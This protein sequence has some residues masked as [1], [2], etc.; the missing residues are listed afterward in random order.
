MQYRVLL[1]W[2]DF[3]MLLCRFTRCFAK[4][5]STASRAAPAEFGQATGYGGTTQKADIEK[6]RTM[7]PVSS[8]IYLKNASIRCVIQVEGARSIEVSFNADTADDMPWKFYPQQT[9]VKVT[10]RNLFI[11]N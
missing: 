1:Q 7:K 2:L 6:F 4:Y 10:L 11:V 5:V 3:R 9:T 8:F